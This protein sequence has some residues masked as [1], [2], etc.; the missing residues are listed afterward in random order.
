ME[1]ALEGVEGFFVLRVVQ[2]RSICI[3][4]ESASRKV[5]LSFDP[6]SIF[7]SRACSALASLNLFSSSSLR[8]GSDFSNPSSSRLTSFITR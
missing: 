5:Q 4:E 8:D 3:L 2:L 1:K 6:S 7:R